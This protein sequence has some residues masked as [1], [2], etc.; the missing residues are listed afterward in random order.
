M[1]GYDMML[2]M[3][4]GAEGVETSIKLARKW[5]YE[6]KNIPKNEVTPQKVVCFTSVLVVVCIFLTGICLC[7]YLARLLKF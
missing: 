2:P 7:F 4:T 1:F 5:G 6:K 3:N